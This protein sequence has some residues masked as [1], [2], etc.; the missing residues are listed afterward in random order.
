MRIVIA[1]FTAALAAVPAN[2]QPTASEVDAAIRAEVE[3]FR[4][5][6]QNPQIHAAVR[7]QSAQKT[8]IS[9]IRAVDMSWVGEEKLNPRMQVLLSNP[10]AKSL[11]TLT[12]AWPG[13]REAFVM[14]NQ[15]A[16]VC[17]TRKTTDYWQGDEDKWQ[18]S[19]AEGKGA[20]YVGPPEEDE[21]TGTMLTHVSVPVMDGGKAIG[22][23]T[24]GVDRELLRKRMTKP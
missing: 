23:L 6:T 24:V 21:S 4:S 12:G 7:D 17:M 15:G 2:A 11:L 8:P 14:D 1:I 5:W 13:Y 19:W 16:L 20:V 22:V 3:V 10:C 18:K 9:R